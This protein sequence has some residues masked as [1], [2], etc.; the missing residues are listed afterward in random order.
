MLFHL[1]CDMNHDNI[2][3]QHT[4]FGKPFYY[5]V[6]SRMECGNDLGRPEE[7]LQPRQR[8]DEQNWSLKE[9]G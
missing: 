1:N 9:E 8:P 5:L 7:E 6:V 4:H 3:G 2:S